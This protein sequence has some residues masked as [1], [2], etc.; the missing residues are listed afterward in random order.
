MSMLGWPGPINPTNPRDFPMVILWMLAKSPKQW[1]KLV[2]P[3]DVDICGPPFSTQ[4]ISQA[5][6]VGPHFSDLPSPIKIVDSRPRL[7]TSPG[8]LIEVAGSHWQPGE[9]SQCHGK[10]FVTRVDPGCQF[11]ARR[12]SPICPYAMHGI[13][14]ATF[15]L[16]WW[17]EDS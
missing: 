5:S 4:Q 1:L 9:P 10:G 15:G 7:P 17:S 3:R 11:M 6:T 13:C 14:I 2:N 12:L 8:G 16:F